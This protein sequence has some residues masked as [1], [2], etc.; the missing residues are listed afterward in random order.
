MPSRL[1]CLEALR[2]LFPRVSGVWEYW[3]FRLNEE[4][5]WVSKEGATDTLEETVSDNDIAI[6]NQEL[7]IVLNRMT[8]KESKAALCLSFIAYPDLFDITNLGGGIKRLKGI[9]SIAEKTVSR[10]HAKYLRDLKK[11]I[12][13][14]EKSNEVK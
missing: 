5:E 7:Y 4:I 14:L 10:L 8:F 13:K 9:N 2:A 1:D 6:M 3:T 11:W 12:Q